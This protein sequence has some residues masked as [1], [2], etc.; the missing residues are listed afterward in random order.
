VSDE[1]TLATLHEHYQQRLY[2]MDL[3][4]QQR[5]EAQSRALDAALLAADRAVQAALQA[6]DRAVQKAELAADKRF[7]LL[8]ELRVGVATTDQLDALEKIVTELSKRSENR[9]GFGEGKA[10]LWAVLAGVIIIA[11]A[12]TGLILNATSS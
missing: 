8:N 6:A 12:A 5:Y 7:E 9:A 4:Y 3:R 11:I 1:W 2:D 10:A